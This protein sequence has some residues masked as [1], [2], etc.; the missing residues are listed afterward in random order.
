MGI[1]GLTSFIDNNPHLLKDHQLH[2]CRV[3]IDGSNLYHF[4]YYYCNVRFQFG[5]DYDTYLRKIKM[6]FNM[7]KSCNVEVFVVFDGAY[8]VDGRKLKTTMGRA[9]DRVYASQRVMHGQ[10]GTLIPCLA[11]QT[12]T[13]ALDELGIPH[14][15]SDFEADNQLATLANLWNCPVISNDSDFYIFDL[16]GGYI[17]LD[18]I[19]F[20]PCHIPKESSKSEQSVTFLS[21]QYYHVDEFIK[22]FKSLNR[23][24]LPLFATMLGNDYV[25]AAAFEAFYQKKTPKTASKR[26]SASK[27]HQKIVSV[28]YWLEEKAYKGA[29]ELVS[30]VLSFIRQERRQQV[31]KLLTDSISGYTDTQEFES[32]DLKRFL[33]GDRSA[34]KQKTE[35]VTDVTGQ[36]LPSWFIAACRCGE[37]PVFL[38]NAAL[39][40][41]VIQPIQVHSGSWNYC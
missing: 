28:L 6:I 9:R 24:V 21:V 23:S 14:V 30:Q 10:N 3:V 26:Y 4:L 38:L 39:L 5:G 29:T 7:F 34:A 2:D 22:C 1:H 20:R 13:E 17:P 41:H 37:V 35:A 11:R 19:D 8:A 32:F 15:T 18:Y 31:E 36:C 40:K 25:D 12:F 33:E 16:T 27:K